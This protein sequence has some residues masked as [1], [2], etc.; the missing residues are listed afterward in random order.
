MAVRLPRHLVAARPWRSRVGRLLHRA[1]DEAGW[2]A[3]DRDRDPG[4][5]PI[6]AE[7]EGL[8]MNHERKPRVL[9]LEVEVRTSERTGRPWYAAWLGKARI[10]GF[11]AD[12][13]NERGHK[14]IR[15]FVEE[16]EPRDGPRKAP[17]KLPERDS[18]SKR[19][20][21]PST[22]H[23]RPAASGRPFRRAAEKARRERV[24]GEIL[25]ER[26]GGELDDPIPF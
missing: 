1:L 21:D 26:G 22:A 24:A 23:A 11:E 17:A 20:Q 4:R 8:A 25:D 6:R 15:L 16:P 13:P 7:L 5:A 9:L 12:E 18:A 14:V 19:V 3:L 2:G 10:I